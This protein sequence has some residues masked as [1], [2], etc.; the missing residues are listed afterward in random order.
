M[1]S[2]L[3]VSESNTSQIS[4][5]SPAVGSDVLY[6]FVAPGELISLSGQLVTSAVVANRVVTLHIDDGVSNR[7]VFSIQWSAIAQVASL[8]TIY[9][10]LSNSGLG[11]V[12]Q[13]TAG[14]NPVNVAGVPRIRMMPGWRIRT[15]T[16]GI[17]VGDQ[18]SNFRMAIAV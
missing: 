10:A 4:I 13:A 8:T 11:S 6:T 3:Y 5:P 14:P 7:D 18:F 16:S 12:S 9:T 17:D 1:S 2:P 15:V